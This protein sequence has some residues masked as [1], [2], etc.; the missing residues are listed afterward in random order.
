[1]PFQPRIGETVFVETAKVQPV[2]IEV[3]FTQI[4]PTT[5]L[6]STVIFPL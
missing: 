5:Y 2:H 6:P 4:A 3:R 1:M